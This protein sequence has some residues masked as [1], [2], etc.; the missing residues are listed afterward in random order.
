M[1]LKATK[2]DREMLTEQLIRL[3][4]IIIEERQAAKN[5]SLDKMLKLTAQKES[6]LKEISGVIEI[7]DGLTPA[8]KELSETVFSENLRNAYF[9]LSALSWVRESM[10]F[11][12]DRMFHEFYEEDGSKVTGKFSGALLSGRI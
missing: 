5:L 12:G 11:F 7:V 8:E 10:G 2:M 9:F 4:D 3:R 1:L 6:L